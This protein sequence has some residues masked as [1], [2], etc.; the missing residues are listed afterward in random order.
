M[1][2]G[3]AAPLANSG[4]SERLKSRRAVILFDRPGTSSGIARALL[5]RRASEMVAGRLTVKVDRALGL[6]DTSF[7][8]AK[9][10]FACWMSVSGASIL[11]SEL[12]SCQGG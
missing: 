9:V 6:K 5:P 1:L 12:C 4:T 3:Y 10:S 2:P 8:G 11:S 7:L